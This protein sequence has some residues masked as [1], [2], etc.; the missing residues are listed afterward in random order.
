MWNLCFVVVFCGLSVLDDVII[1]ILSVKNL[2]LNEQCH[3]IQ[4]RGLKT[5]A[6]KKVKKNLKVKN[7]TTFT[8]KPQEVISQNKF[9]LPILI[10][11]WDLDTTRQWSSL[12]VPYEV[13]LVFLYFFFRLSFLVIFFGALLISLLYPISLLSLQIQLLGFKWRLLWYLTYNALGE[14]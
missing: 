7:W 8:K 6:F 11:D 12:L 10:Q 14:F 2:L 13:V 1:I 5:E 9:G 3:I 4:Q